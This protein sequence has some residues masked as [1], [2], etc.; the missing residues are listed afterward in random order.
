MDAARGRTIAVAAALVAACSTVPRAG[1]LPEGATTAPEPWRPVALEAA[2][3]EARAVVR[4]AVRNRGSTP[5]TLPA[6]AGPFLRVN[7]LEGDTRHP[8]AS[9][10]LPQRVDWTE[11]APGTSREADLDLAQ[12]CVFAAERPSRVEIVLDVP[13]GAAEARGAPGAWT[14]RSEALFVDL[15]PLRYVK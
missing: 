9:A 4:V 14:G 10:R 8:C 3:F 2:G 13:P 6:D 11:V 12:R 15:P 5:L 7:R 1:R